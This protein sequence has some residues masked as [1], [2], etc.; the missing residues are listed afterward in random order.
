MD[1]RTQPDLPQYAPDWAFFLDVDGT[2]LE[3][4]AH[5]HDVQV[6]P[7]LIAALHDLHAVCD[8]AV[9]LVTGRSL[10]DLDAILMPEHL[11]A[12]GQHGLERRDGL[13]RVRRRAIDTT[14]LAGAHAAL[15]GFARTHPGM[16]IEDKGAV[17]ALHYRQAGTQAQAAR[18]FVESLAAGL[19]P[20]YKAQHGKMVAEIKPVAADKG[21]AIAEFVREPPF[22]DRTPVFIGDDV[23]D[24]DGFAYVNA[25]GGV[26][27]KVGAGASA[28]AHRL[29]DARAV[30]DFLEGYV[31]YRH[32]AAGDAVL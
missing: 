26:S 22:R 29:A 1:T 5:P 9:A 10:A 4:A 15:A 27:V 19:G 32:R 23:T 18:A 7:E 17:L 11:P 31:R 14:A 20:G 30:L 21:T 12:A 28:A 16:L 2:L 24:E 8:G 25:V 6:R 3:L 13:G